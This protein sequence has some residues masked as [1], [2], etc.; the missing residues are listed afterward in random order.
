MVINPDRSC[1]SFA[2]SHFQIF[3]W[4]KQCLLH[5]T[6]CF[7]NILSVRQTSMVGWLIALNLRTINPTPLSHAEFASVQCMHACRWC[8]SRP[9][10]WLQVWLGT[11]LTLVASWCI[12]NDTHHSQASQLRTFLRSRKEKGRSSSPLIILSLQARQENDI[13]CNICL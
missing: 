11:A 4:R 3:I 1:I 7:F 8:N 2:L 13:N 9:V 10:Q 6:F 5:Y 12:T